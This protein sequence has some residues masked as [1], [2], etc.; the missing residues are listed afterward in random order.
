MTV[1]ITHSGH[2]AFQKG[3]YVRKSGS[4][5]WTVKHING[6]PGIPLG[7]ARIT[8]TEPLKVPY[9]VVVTA[10]RSPN[11]PLLAAN[12]GDVE[13]GGFVV[14]LWETVADRTVQNAG[15]SFL[16]MAGER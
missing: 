11:T 12:Y 7:M 13:E 5:A 14:H 4:G 15:F 6:F 3:A 16:V 9:G 1:N 10:H 8:F 2:V